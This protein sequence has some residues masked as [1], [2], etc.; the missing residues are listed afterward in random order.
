MHIH[1]LF[2]NLLRN[3]SSICQGKLVAANTI[4]M[5]DSEPEV[6]E[7]MPSICTNISDLTLLFV[8][9]SIAQVSKIYDTFLTLHVLIPPL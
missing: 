3:A 6:T 5:G 7:A 4:T 8:K 1:I 9:V 2:S